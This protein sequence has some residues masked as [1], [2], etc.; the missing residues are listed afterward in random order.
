MMYR[1]TMI[2]RILLVVIA[3]ILSFS[4][5]IFFDFEFEKKEMIYGI[6]TNFALL[7]FAVW[8]GFSRKK[9]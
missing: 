4:D 7:S 8:L 6:A 1:I 5:S 2:I 9:D 3:V